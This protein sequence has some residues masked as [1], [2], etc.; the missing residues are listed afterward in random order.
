M[1]YLGFLILILFGGIVLK[2]V[3]ASTPFSYTKSSVSLTGGKTQDVSSSDII[4]PVNT[5]TNFVTTG[6]YT[7]T[8]NCVDGSDNMT[9]TTQEININ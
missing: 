9:S 6:T 8:V 1:K 7:F 3:P 4:I 2:V 5:A